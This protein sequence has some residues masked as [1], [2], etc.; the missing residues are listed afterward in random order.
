MDPLAL[1]TRDQKD[2]ITAANE[3]DALRVQNDQAREL[4]AAMLAEL[5]TLRAALDEIAALG[6]GPLAEI[7]RDALI[8]SKG[9]NV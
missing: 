4:Y 7:A 8:R 3:R 9:P 5:N 1:V 2:F 6:N